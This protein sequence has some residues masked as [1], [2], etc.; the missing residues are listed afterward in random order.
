MT[1]QQ[2]ETMFGRLAKFLGHALTGEKAGA[3]RAVTPSLVNAVRW[4]LLYSWEMA[5]AHALIGERV[6]ALEW[7]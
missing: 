5:T 3:L 2:P 4:D 7:L 6:Q 1:S